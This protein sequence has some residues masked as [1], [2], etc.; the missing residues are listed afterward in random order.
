MP[1]S[2]STRATIVSKAALPEP[3]TMAAR[4]TVSGTA[5]DASRRPVSIPLRRWGERPGPA[6][7]PPPAGGRWGGRG[8]AAPGGPR[9]PPPAGRAPRSRASPA[10]AP[11]SRRP[12]FLS[13]RAALTLGRWRRRPPSASARSVPP[14]ADATPRRA[15]ARGR[16][17]A[18]ACV[19]WCRW[20]RRPR[21]SLA[22]LSDQ[23]AEVPPADGQVD[24]PLHLTVERAGP[25]GL[26]RPGGQRREEARDG[27]AQPQ[28][29]AELV[30]GE[31]D[32][33]AGLVGKQATDDRVAAAHR[34]LGDVC[35]GLGE[36]QQQRSPPEQ[37]QLHPVDALPRADQ[38]QGEPLD[39]LPVRGPESLGAVYGIGAHRADQPHP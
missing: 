30:L 7:R 17:Q 39:L 5:P 29:V 1:G 22:R 32:L 14:S 36:G 9:S 28:P 16:G 18:A 38:P 6:A 10:S 12:G 37:P 31:D 23:A 21:P 26:P 3:I 27:G 35:D 8:R 33:A 13:G 20:R 4:S 11:G 19:R 25:V 34:P 24:A 2:R 15:R